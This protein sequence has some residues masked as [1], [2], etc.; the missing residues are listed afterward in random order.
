MLLPLFLLGTGLLVLDLPHV[1][2]LDGGG[3][4]NQLGIMRGELDIQDFD[5]GLLI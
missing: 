1:L 2:A 4:A 3:A 5:R